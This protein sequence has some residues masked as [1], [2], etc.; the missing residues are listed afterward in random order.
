MTLTP[1]LTTHKPHPQEAVGE[2]ILTNGLV[3]GLFGLLKV[4]LSQFQSCFKTWVFTD[5]PSLNPL[6]C[7]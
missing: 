4:Y 3:S 6:I 5:S 7:W 2:S 1:P